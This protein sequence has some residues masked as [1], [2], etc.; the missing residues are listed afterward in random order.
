[1]E[2]EKPKIFVLDT[3]VLLHDS[4]SIFSFKEHNVYIP[5]EA[6]EELDRVKKGNDTLNYNSRDSARNLDEKFPPEK[7][8]DGGASLGEG[9]G[10]IR[11]IMSFPYNPEVEKYF[12]PLEVKNGYLQKNVDHHIINTAYC[13]S[14]EEKGSEIILVS[15]DVNVRLKAKS[16]GLRAED[17]KAD[18]VVDVNSLYRGAR[19]IIVPKEKIDQLYKLKYFEFSGKERLDPNECLILTTHGVMGVNQTA[20][21]IHEDGIIKLVTKDGVS[22][23]GIRPKNSEQAFALSFLL[24]PAITLVTIIGKAGTGKTILSIAAALDQAMERDG[25]ELY[26]EVLFTRQTISLCDN[27]IGFLPGTA[28]EKVNPY[29]QGLYDNLGV[30]KSDTKNTNKVQRLQDEG[31][32]IIEP[33]SL[34]RGRSLAKKFFIIDEAQNLTPGEIKAIITRAGEGTK[35]VLIGDI[36]QTDTPLLDERSN[37]LS[38]LIEKMRGQDFYAHAVL[39]KG[40]RSHMSEVAGNLL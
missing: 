11:I 38:V 21:G 28:K 30:I 19:K 29:M 15:K 36:S 31:K 4:L 34:I 37:G 35:I 5:I 14:K 27:D 7:L 9:L 2:T 40:E 10:L 3:N 13:L 39:K 1:M 22:A 6:I 32:I 17:Y 23:F 18:K 25:E 8:F 16:L 33:L 24:N 26:E 12:S 20:L